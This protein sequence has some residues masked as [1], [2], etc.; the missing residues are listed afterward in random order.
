MI[1]IN[2]MDMKQYSKMG[3]KITNKKIPTSKEKLKNGSFPKDMRWKR[4]K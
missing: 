3:K 4:G 2:K 1:K